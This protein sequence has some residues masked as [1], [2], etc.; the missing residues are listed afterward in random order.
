MSLDRAQVLL[1][2]VETSIALTRKLADWRS[3]L[4]WLALAGALALSIVLAG[5][6]PL[7]WVAVGLV[8]A[9][10][11]AF[12]IT[13][14]RQL[15]AVSSQVVEQAN[16]DIARDAA[17]DNAS[18]DRTRV[19][20]VPEHYLQ[21]VDTIRP[22][23][24][25]ALLK[26]PPTVIRGQ[27]ATERSSFVAVAVYGVLMLAGLILAAVIPLRWMF[28]SW[29]PLLYGRF[30]GLPFSIVAAVASGVVLLLGYRES[31]VVLDTNHKLS[32]LLLAVAT[33]ELPRLWRLDPS[34]TQGA[35]I[36]WTP[37][38]YVIDPAQMSMS[39]R[40]SRR[41]LIVSIVL[42]VLYVV[43]ILFTVFFAVI[44]HLSTINGLNDIPLT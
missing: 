44:G 29:A 11:V 22:A 42:I 12:G 30:E 28:L 19:D 8:V 20:E 32:P 1:D 33:A 43:F 18:W 5:R 38:G 23:Q 7:A 24:L 34:F 4:A 40:R 17:V 6:W 31:F 36:R 35:A 10:T 25:E 2:D 41:L 26:V 27:L 9:L 14:R 15:Q 3:P 37:T 39:P 13:R 21:P 16:S